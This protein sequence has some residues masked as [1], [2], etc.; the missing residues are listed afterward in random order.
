MQM[1]RGECSGD[2]PG[3]SRFGFDSGTT[4]SRTHVRVNKRCSCALM[5]LL[6]LSLVL[7]AFSSPTGGDGANANAEALGTESD[8]QES[9]AKGARVDSGAAE[10]PRLAC[11]SKKPCEQ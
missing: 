7:F 8:L 2:E 3:D 11:Q 9:D 1:V 5:L 4:E 10:S 6:L